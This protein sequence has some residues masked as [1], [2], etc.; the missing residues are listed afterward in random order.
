MLDNAE[1][2]ALELGKTEDAKM[3]ANRLKVQREATHKMTYNPETGKY[4]KGQQVDQAFAL[5]A[6]VTPESEKKKVYR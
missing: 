5:L 1:K 6:G 4:G 3:Y 2:M